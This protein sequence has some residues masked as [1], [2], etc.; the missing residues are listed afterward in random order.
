[1]SDSTFASNGSVLGFLAGLSRLRADDRRAM[2]EAEAEP[3]RKRAIEAERHHEECKAERE[4]LRVTI[5]DQGR[6]IEKLE[7]SIEVERK[8]A[9]GLTEMVVSLSERLNK[10]EAIRREAERGGGAD[11]ERLI[12]GG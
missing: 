3:N 9:D 5:A 6:K 2:I 10:V 11:H 7:T 8:R 1:M 12:G 4:A